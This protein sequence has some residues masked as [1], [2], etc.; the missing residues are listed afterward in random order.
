MGIIERK[1][2]ILLNTPHL[3]TA[4]GSVA[5]FDTDLRSKLK[6]CKINFLP[7][8]SGSGDPSPTNVRNISGWNG[9]NGCHTRKNLL[10]ID[11]LISSPSNT[12]NNF[13]FK[14]YLEL[15]L[16]PNTYYT[17]STSYNNS[18]LNVLYANGV[19]G[20]KNGV[21]ADTPRT[22]LSSSDGIV[23]LMLYD[24]DGIEKFENKE[25]TVQLEEGNIVTSYEPV[26]NI[27]VSW[28]S[29]TGILYGG[30]VDLTN[31]II[32]ATMKMMTF[33]GNQNWN[34]AGIY[35]G[36]RFNAR[37]G[38][39][40]GDYGSGHEDVVACNYLKP[41]PNGTSAQVNI[42][43]NNIITGSNW[44]FGVYAN[45][46]VANTVSEWIEYLTEHPLQVVYKL[47][48]PLIYQLAPQQIKSIIGRNNI[49][50]DAGNVEVKFWT[51]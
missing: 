11:A 24:H 40:D 31:W 44:G 46:T 19:N 29:E 3:E 5:T 34:D 30:Y 20:D 25:V 2:A 49:W 21:K 48:T 36:H 51:H 35:T 7:V 37:A 9:I 12:V 23:F 43:G 38:M 10:N 28:Q 22:I 18:G 1:K 42:Y 8:Q 47:A 45:V 17:V 33:N 6:E 39:S 16:K 13:N 41:A 27:P 50:S 26:N 14:H 32:V 15:K 4:S